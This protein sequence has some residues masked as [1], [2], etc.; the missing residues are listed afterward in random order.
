MEQKP[1][2]K[3]FYENV[4]K[5]TLENKNYR[6]VVYTG[7]NQQFVYMSLKP[8]DDIHMEIHPNHDQFIRIEKGEGKAIVNGESFKLYDGIG[9]IIPAGAAHRIINSSDKNDLKLYS[10][11]SPPEH[12]DARL[13]INNPDKKKQKGGDSIMNKSNNIIAHKYNKYKEKYLKLK[14]KF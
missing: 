14:N 5:N 7:K 6:Y 9:I 1:K 8:N 13:D 3:I 4:E 11:Y 12:P 10:I 2:Q